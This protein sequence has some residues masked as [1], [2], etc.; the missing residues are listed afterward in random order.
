MG[1]GVCLACDLATRLI[2]LWQ[3]A[4]KHSPA[5]TSRASTDLSDASSVPT[6]ERLTGSAD[7]NA[8]AMVDL[9]RSYNWTKVAI[10]YEN[11]EHCQAWYTVWARCR[12]RP[13][14]LEHHT[15]RCFAC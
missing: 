11:G 13:L 1:R 7:H 14:S 9:A 15:I 12:C 3:S 5:Y 10:L 6:L 4:C 2:R 8:Y